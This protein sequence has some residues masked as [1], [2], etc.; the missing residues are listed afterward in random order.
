M[1]F[2]VNNREDQ[3]AI[4]ALARL[5]HN[6][7]FRSYHQYISRALDALRK[8]GDTLTG[9]LLPWNQG[10]CQFAQEVLDLPEIA[11]KIMKNNQ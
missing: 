10:K 5:R 2:D 6:E 7:D 4:K 8:K 11:V 1:V 9:D 3:Q